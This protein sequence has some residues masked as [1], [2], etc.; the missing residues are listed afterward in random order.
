MDYSNIFII[1]YWY[2]MKKII[3][4]YNFFNRL[5]TNIINYYYIYYPPIVF[6][7]HIIKNSKIIH[8]CN[9][10]DVILLEDT[11]YDYIVYN[12]DYNEMILSYLY[13]NINEIN[14]I[15]KLLPCNF[16]FISV[17][18]KTNN[19]SYDIT[20]FLKDNKEY[21]YICGATLFNKNFMNWTY[22]NYIKKN[23]N[24]LDDYS[25]TIMDNLCNQITLNKNQSIKLNQDDYEI[26]ENY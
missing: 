8:K 25:I 4:I 14:E 19:N 23:L 18:I 24:E 6:N 16:K 15:N 5:I 7:I 1:I 3:I 17:L 9:F 26:L 2:L 21:Y 20:L 13:N 10:L 11:E 12:E 22:I